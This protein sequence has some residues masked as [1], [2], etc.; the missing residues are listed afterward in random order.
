MP[1]LKAMV[2]VVNTNVIQKYRSSS[3]LSFAT[4]LANGILVATPRRYST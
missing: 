3:L 2:S 4:K 1:S